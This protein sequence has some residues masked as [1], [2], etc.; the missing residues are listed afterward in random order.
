MLLRV[1]RPVALE[2]LG[3]DARIG[4]LGG[5]QLRRPERGAPGVEVHRAEL[6]EAQQVADA[7]RRS[8]A[9]PSLMTSSR[10]PGRIAEGVVVPDGTGSDSPGVPAE[11]RVGRIDQDAQQLVRDVVGIDLVAGVDE[12]VRA[13]LRDP[14]PL[15][16]FSIIRSTVG[17]AS[18]P[19]PCGLRHETWTMRRPPGSTGGAVNDGSEGAL[20]TVA[21]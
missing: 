4:L 3:R 5:G 1:V 20:G 18:T 10:V 15:S 14:R 2:L 17:R 21:R 19:G 9:S 11:E 8:R 16:A 12:Q 7:V 13:G 6:A